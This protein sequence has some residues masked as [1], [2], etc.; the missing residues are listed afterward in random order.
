MY[1]YGPISVHSIWF[2]CPF[3]QQFKSVLRIRIRTDP[4]S[5]ASADSESG[6]ALGIRIQ[7]RIQEGQNDPQKCRIFKFWRA[8]CS[9]LR[10]EDFSC[11]LYTVFFGCKF[12]PI[13]GH[14]NPGSGSGSVSGSALT[15]KKLNQFGSTTL[16]YI[17]FIVNFLF[18]RVPGACYFVNI[19]SFSGAAAEGVG[20]NQPTVRWLS[21]PHGP[22]TERAHTGPQYIGATSSNIQAARQGIFKTL[23]ASQAGHHPPNTFNI[24]LDIWIIWEAKPAILNILAAMADYLV[25]WEA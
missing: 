1:W 19:K 21:P 4:H 5:F 20:G 16:V 17:F 2:N 25:S 18:V 23:A 7:I 14:P 11:S 13:F 9:L 24:S 22:A 3:Q 10:D 6:S 12:C 8:R 15:K